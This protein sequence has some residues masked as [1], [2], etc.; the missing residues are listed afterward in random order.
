MIKYN[1][2]S[3]KEPDEKFK[4]WLLIEREYIN[5]NFS[6]DNLTVFHN[7]FIKILDKLVILKTNH[8]NWLT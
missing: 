5:M 7:N 8:L 2:L 4:D 1:D 3:Y 6:S